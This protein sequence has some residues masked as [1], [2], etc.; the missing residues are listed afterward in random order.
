MMSK[1]IKNNHK[2]LLASFLAGTITMSLLLILHEMYLGHEIILGLPFFITPFINGVFTASISL[3]FSKKQV[4]E[5]ENK[6]KKEKELF[7]SLMSSTSDLVYFKDIE[8][9]F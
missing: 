7:D 2:L 1:T 4:E 5:S 9:R 8:H 6:L 3:I